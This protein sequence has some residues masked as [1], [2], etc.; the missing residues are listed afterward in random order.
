MAFNQATADAICQRLAEGESLRNAIV[1]WACNLAGAA[2]LPA[3]LWLQLHAG[4]G[5]PPWLGGALS[6]LACA[7]LMIV[8]RLYVMRSYTLT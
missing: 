2:C 1:Y 5:L 3:G 8:G 4:I 6:G 7:G